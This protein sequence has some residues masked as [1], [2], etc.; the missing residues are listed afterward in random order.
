MIPPA[1]VRSWLQ[2]LLKRQE[3]DDPVDSADD[4]ESAQ[5]LCE[6][7]IAMLQAGQATSDVENILTTVA[8]AYR[9]APVRLVVLPTVMIV[10]LRNAE[11]IIELDVVRP[12]ALRLDQAAEI[13]NL[14]AEAARARMEP[15]VAL[16]RLSAIRASRSRFGG[17]LTFLGHIL[18]TLGFGLVLDPVAQAIPAYLFLG[19][20][21]GALV[22]L[23]RRLP[24]FEAVLPV[25]VAFIATVLTV[26]F[27]SSWAGE[28]PLRIIAPALV[29]FL[30]GST[31]TI[32]AIELTSNQVIAGASRVTYGIAQ[33]LLLVFG[34]V[35]GA[36]VTGGFQH[37][38]ERGAELGWWAPLA[39][40][41]LLAIGY[42]LF[43]SAPK[44]S[45]PWLLLSLV[46]TYGALSLGTLILGAELSPFAGALVVIPFAR[47]IAR[48]R[49][50]PPPAI[51]TLA[52][53]WL[54]VPGALGFLGVSQTVTGGAGGVNQVLT[55]GISVFAIAVGILVSS[56]LTNAAATI[57]FRKIR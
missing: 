36:A 24:H 11:R 28:I 35:A 53:F 46:V 26:L 47:L 50:A 15:S 4:R 29:S 22:M 38:V 54:L 45:L 25:V 18:L 8:A 51:S 32:G 3:Q 5:L 7:G 27:L 6:L 1:R 34:V 55:T 17:W 48:F 19:A 49:T 13:D 31:L 41:L 39:G 42:L 2:R 57:R 20:I 37:S 21:V 33:L 43:L 30:P 10:Q 52:S 56:A 9:L 40:L 44:G 23:G 14:V 12:G 16:A